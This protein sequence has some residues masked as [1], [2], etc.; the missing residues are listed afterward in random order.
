M[1]WFSGTAPVYTPRATGFRSLQAVSLFRP[2]AAIPPPRPFHTGIQGTTYAES[3]TNRSRQRS[4]NCNHASRN[5]QSARDSDRSS[6][7]SAVRMPPRDL[8]ERT[9]LLALAV[10]ALCRR[11]PKTDEAQEVARQLRRAGNS[12]RNNHRAA[13]KGRSRRLFEDKLGVACEEADECVDWLEYLRDAGIRD[14]P[15]LLDEARQIACILTSSHKTAKA[16]SARM[17][18]LPKS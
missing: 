13:R 10:L 4:R 5:R 16:N 7:C 3:A 6:T 8:R 14:D 9:R 2:S 12:V 1:F 17:K 15:R 18:E 11:L